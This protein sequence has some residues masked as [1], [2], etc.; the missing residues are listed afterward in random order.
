[1]PEAAASRT[2]LKAGF[3]TGV[4]ALL[5][6]FAIASPLCAATNDSSM[7]LL[8]SRLTAYG[9][10][11]DDDSAE[12]AY[13][14]HHLLAALSSNALTGPLR[15]ADQGWQR[16]ERTVGL[17]AFLRGSGKNQ[18]S[19]FAALWRQGDDDAPEAFWLVPGYRHA[20]GVLPWRDAA[21]LGFHYRRDLRDDVRLNLEPFYGMGWAGA[22][23]LWGIKASLAF[24]AHDHGRPWGVLTARFDDG[25]PALNDHARGHDVR[26]TWM[27]SDHLS[28]NVGTQARENA[29]RGG[30]ALVRWH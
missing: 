8:P 1:M 2:S 20:D 29:P 18:P 6:G 10:H 4:F 13:G 28:L 3:R 14:R 24:G 5:L 25:D 23:G 21:L 17:D 15:F 7:P 11:R 30:Y 19:F 27:A 12:A 16:F 22:R 26:G 9:P